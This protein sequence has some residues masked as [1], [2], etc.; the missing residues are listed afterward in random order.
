MRDWGWKHAGR[1]DYSLRGVTLEIQP[2]ERVLLLGASG[3]GKST[4]LH[5]LAGLTGPDS[6]INGEAEGVL[7]LDGHS[8]QQRRRGVGLVSQDPETQLVMAQAGDD[9]AFGLENLA[10]DPAEIWDRVDAGLAEVGF[11]YGRH[12]STASLSGG[13]KQRLVIAGALAMRPRLLLL[14]EPTA[15]LDP[16]GAELVRSL[17]AELLSAT[18]ATMVIVEHRVAQVMDLVDRVVVVE[19]GGGVLADGVPSEIF[20]RHGAALARKGVWVP[21]Y[22]PS[23]ALP[24]A[25][26]GPVLLEAVGVHARTPRELG[27][28]GAAPRT[29]LEGVDADL[30][31][32]TTTALTG[33]NGA[34]KSTLL[35]M[36]AGLAAPYDGTIAPRGV[37]A[38]V[39]ARPLARWPARRLARHVGTV[40]QHA[41][42]QFVTATV[43]DELR[44]APLKAG[45]PEH[46][47]DAWVD[48]LLDRLRLT[49][50]ADVHPFTLSGGE[51]RRLSVATALSSGPAHAPDL[52]V[53][54]EPT[55]GQDTITWT[56]LVELLAEL[57][58]QG[59][60]VLA[61]THDD[62]FMDRCVDAR[63]RV[64]EGTVRPVQQGDGR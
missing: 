15:N 34:G 7:L 10:V 12:R 16:A 60:A 54:D 19:A 17:I 25:P 33:P 45:T 55:F 14:D 1:E 47:A 44:F 4:L 37:L 29:V 6:A 56:E 58:A 43:R 26:G 18:Q 28:R 24:P 63:L 32:G 49:E 8:A 51:K 42:D 27:I 48:E 21:G 38:E 13:E 61:A 46:E 64:A 50:L 23:P 59:R 9:V 31:A 20:A 36:L 41:E 40:F 62:L 30:L 11:P 53:L 5:S 57:R 52:L 22:E 3:A 39:D 35:M 2:G